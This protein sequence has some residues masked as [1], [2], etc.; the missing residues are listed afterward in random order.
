MGAAR[1]DAPGPLRGPG[2]ARRRRRRRRCTVVT[3]HRATTLLRDHRTSRRWRPPGRSR[4]RA[5][6]DAPV[7]VVHLSSAA[8][9]D[10]VRRAKAAGVRVTAETCPHYLVLT[11][12]RY[13]DPDPPRCARFLIAPPLRSAADR[14][15]LWVG[16][17]DGS[18][19]L[20]AS[21]HVPDRLAVEK[22]EAARGVPF[23]RDQQRRAR[24][25]DAADD[26]LQ[27]GRGARPDHRRAA[28]SISSRRAPARRFG[29]ARQGR[30][31]GRA[32][33]RPRRSS[34]PRPAGS[35]APTTCTT[36]A[37]TRRTRASRSTGAVRDGPRPRTRGHPRRVHSSGDAAPGPS[38]SAARS[39]PDRPII[40]GGRDARIDGG[41]R[42]TAGVRGG[43]RRPLMLST[44]MKLRGVLRRVGAARAAPHP[45]SSIA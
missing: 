28:W 36:R 15:A 16:L 17:A 1:R 21:D 29:L 2:P 3:C 5:P 11:E 27:R 39:A 6:A 18:L 9:L 42:S 19:D 44:G 41:P 38:S 10:E 32:R 20:V 7:H 12:E 22:A 30:D 25:R 4:S 24:H 43:H 40:A 13:D 37:T 33:R 34:T 45:H 35:S 23:N 26:P 8:A 31:R 14:D